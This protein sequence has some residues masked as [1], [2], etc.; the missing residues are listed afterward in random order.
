MESM[1]KSLEER[2]HDAI[3]MTPKQIFIAGGRGEV[4]DIGQSECLPWPRINVKLD[5]HSIMSMREGGRT[6]QH[7]LHCG[8][9]YF[10]GSFAPI[11][12]HEQSGSGI[13][14]VLYQN[15]LRVVYA[16][17]NNAEILEQKFYHIY[18]TLSM[19]TVYAFKSLDEF[20]E[21]E[22][23]PSQD[24]VRR[25]IR[26]I[27]E[28]SENDLKRSHSESVSRSQTLWLQLA[29]HVEENYLGELSREKIAAVFKINPEYVSKLFQRYSN[30][31][32]KEYII[33]RRMEHA[34]Q[35]LLSG[36]YSVDETAWQC[37]FKHTAYFIKTFRLYHGMTP[38]SFRASA[39]VGRHGN[40]K[41][42]SNCKT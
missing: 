24:I 1:K 32:F 37:G 5:G 4:H 21:A 13:S 12:V 38:G 42:S 9:I 40:S 16:K 39:V 3:F 17:M 15:F 30:C 35:M 34:A 7:E 20:C 6:M 31:T 11:K 8:D 28:L 29:H 19:A 22:T 36:K 18:D 33:H 10:I 27:M 23:V 2:L 25:M 14:L 41:I 26:M